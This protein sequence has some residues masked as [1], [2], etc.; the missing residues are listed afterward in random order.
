MRRRGKAPVTADPGFPDFPGRPWFGLYVGE[1]R[2]ATGASNMQFAGIEQCVLVL[3]PP[4]S[5]KTSTIVVPAV[6]A[7]PAAVV[8]TSTKPDVLATTVA[9][10]R[11][12]GNCFVF[13]PTGTVPLPDGALPLRWSPVIGCDQFETAVARAHALASAGRPLAPMSEASHWVERAE[14]LLAPLLFVAARRGRDMGV[15]CRWV[16]S[17]D[18]REPLAAL[19]AE[20]HD[21]PMSVLAGVAATED[22]ERSG[23]FS[24]AAGVLAAYRSESALASARQPNFDPDDF[25]AS[26]DAAFICA[27]AHAQDRLAPIIVALL[28][29]LRA[30]TYARPSSAAP[31]VFALDEVAGIAPL[32]ALPAMAA[33]GASQGLVTLACMQD[34]SQARGR[35]GEAA[36]GFFS[37]FNTKVL[38]PGIADHRTLQL[39]SAMAGDEQVQVRSVNRPDPLMNLLAK[40]KATPSVTTSIAWRPRLPVDVVARG[41]PGAALVLSGAYP[42]WVTTV[43]WWQHPVW[44]KRAGAGH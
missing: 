41:F 22:R 25:T 1:G 10:R 26:A 40:H 44:S 28:D 2:D 18:V 24:T 11:Q 27:P 15:V 20:G 38:F 32:P 3:G 5:G 39:V 34:L 6:L 33:D 42:S 13:D 8:S 9:W 14:A 19:E 36:D 12:L 21:M 4:R 35:W 23:I 17:R 16:L 29:Q 37:L 30:S 43:P 7:A 31:V